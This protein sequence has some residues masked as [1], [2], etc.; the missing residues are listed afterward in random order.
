MDGKR[1]GYWMEL[2][3]DGRTGTLAYVNGVERY[4]PLL[5]SLHLSRLPCPGGISFPP[6]RPSQPTNPNRSHGASCRF[7]LRPR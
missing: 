1:H 6:Y 3:P 5:H 2:A 7:C 4:P